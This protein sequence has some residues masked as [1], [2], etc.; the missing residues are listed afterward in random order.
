MVVTVRFPKPSESSGEKARVIS[1]HF[2]STFTTTYQVRAEKRSD[3]GKEAGGGGEEGLL[4][5]T[6]TNIVRT[7]VS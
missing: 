2:R 5:I 4:T 1:G 3:M 7:V 6:S